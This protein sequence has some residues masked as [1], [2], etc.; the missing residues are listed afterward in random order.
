MSVKLTDRTADI[1]ACV[2]L[3]ALGAASLLYLW[4]YSEEVAFTAIRANDE[5]AFMRVVEQLLT[6]TLGIEYFKLFN[7][8]GYGAIWWAIIAITAAPFKLLGSEQGM[9]ISIRLLSL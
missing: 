8:F 1:A 6:P 5:L 4:H 9:V 2:V 7:S 3:L